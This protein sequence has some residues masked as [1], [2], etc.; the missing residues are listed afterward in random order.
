MR[1]DG[2]KKLLTCLN[3]DNKLEFFKVNIDNDES[4]FKKMVRVE[5]RKGLKRSKQ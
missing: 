3:S 2:D 5:K 4:L 1:Y